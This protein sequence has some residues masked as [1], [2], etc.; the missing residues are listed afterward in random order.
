MSCTVWYEQLQELIRKEA[1]D[2]QRL[3]ILDFKEQLRF[4]SYVKQVQYSQLVCLDAW[5]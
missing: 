2:A 3:I 1:T 4:F 5:S